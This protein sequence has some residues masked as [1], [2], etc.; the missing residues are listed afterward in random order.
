MEPLLRLSAL[1]AGQSGTVLAVEGKGPL[2]RRLQELGLT[3]G[4]PVRCLDRR[5]S[6]RAG[7]YDVRGTV[8][9]LRRSDSAGVWLEQKA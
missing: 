5:R 9:A 3:H 2:T 1:P 4:A 7:C 6:G 8:L